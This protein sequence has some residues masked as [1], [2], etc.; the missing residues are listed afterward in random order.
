MADP[1][2]ALR[3]QARD[4]AA[5]RATI[6]A[7]AGTLA[8]SADAQQKTAVDAAAL[9]QGD[10]STQATTDAAALNTQRRTVLGQLDGLNSTLAGLVAA[11]NLDPCD[12]EA[13]VPL[14]LLPVR[15]ETRYSSNGALQVRIYPDDVH[16]DQLDHGLSDDERAAGT[17]YWTAIWDGSA[18]EDAAWQALLAAV[19]PARAEWVA[20]ALAPD[21]ST[22]PVPAVPG[23][24]PVLPSPPGLAQLP[25]VAHC[26]PDRF[27]VVAIQGT[28][29]S[30][31]TGNPRAAGARRRPP[32]DLGPRPARQ[33]GRP[34]RAGARHAV[35]GRSC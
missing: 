8:A 21:L 29:V 13:D 12:L 27:V 35:A 14:A 26:L 33:A 16:V 17:A 5:Q 28:Q 20:A 1:L 34:D 25:P 18:T 2:D 7:Q 24:V 10:A 4:L 11:L 6:K 30:Q 23:A 19:H 22:R 31:Q 3:Q 9:G 15:L 32:T